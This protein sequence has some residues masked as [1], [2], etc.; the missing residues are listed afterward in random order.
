LYFSSNLYPDWNVLWGNVG[1]QY[2]GRVV[3]S[4]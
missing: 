1:E 2:G 4:V 3:R